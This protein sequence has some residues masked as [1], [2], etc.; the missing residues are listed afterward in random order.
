MWYKETTSASYR[1]GSFRAVNF[2][3][4]DDGYMICPNHRRFYHIYDR[5]VRGN[6]FGRT[7]EVY[8]CE[9]CSDCTLKEKCNKA[10]GNR[11]IT[12]NRELTA[13]HQEVISNLES[14]HG[15]LL[16][17]NRSI[18]VE[19]A[20]GTIKY[21]RDYKRVLRRGLEAV[22]LEFS[23]VSIGFNLHKFHLKRLRQLK[24]AA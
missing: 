11:K 7:E 22:I 15:V 12:L 9:D 13:F 10:Q 4:D 18:Q 20:F 3:S 17:M 23:L 14:V 24:T 5:P 21:N 6:K 16:R 2:V 19:G 8:Q 1:E